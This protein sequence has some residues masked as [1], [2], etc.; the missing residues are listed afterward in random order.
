MNITMFQKATWILHFMSSKTYHYYYDD[1]HCVL[2]CSQFGV[3]AITKYIP[4]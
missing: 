3:E 4:L 2:L 1:Y